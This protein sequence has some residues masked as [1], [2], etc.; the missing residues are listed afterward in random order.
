MKRYAWLWLS[1]VVAVLMLSGCARDAAP[2][3]APSPSPTD[4]SSAGTT[5]TP[6]VL[7]RTVA[8]DG[9][10]VS[11]YPALALGFGG[12]VSGEVLTITVKPGD[13][14]QTGDLIAQLD[15]T[16]LQRSVADAERT[17]ARAR[18]DRALAQT[19]WER[20]IADADQALADA[21]RALTSA[22]LQYSNTSVEEAL[23][24]LNR[25]KD[26]EAQA[27]DNY[28]RAL[29][30]PWEPQDI[31][32][33]YYNG[34]QQA[35]RDRELAEMRYNDSRGANSANYLQLDAR[36]ADVDKAARARAALDAGLALTYD[37]AIED[38]EEQLAQ[39][40]EALA[41]AQ[42]VAPWKAV[43]L[44][45]DI[46]PRASV[47][48]GTPVVTLLSLE[49][50]LRFVS[51][52][53]SEQHIADIR[54]GQRTVVTLR[55]FPDTPLEGAVESVVPQERATTDGTARFTVRVRLGATEL[56]LLPGLTGRAEIFTEASADNP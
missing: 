36:Q 6:V 9:E 25:A 43:V 8:A 11:P 22:R 14:L 37:R 54:P 51:E 47:G 40:T 1:L 20:D 39:A 23:T 56:A 55:T 46:A 7:G 31:R 49:D 12:G 48:A 13:I 16:A 2:E 42:L 24:S 44:S 35:I 4:A 50:G 38:A 18:A 32:D 41:H 30:R 21:Q 29:D 17:L 3:V 10:L 53:L 34:W 26:A 27:E 15:E 52:N 45:V 19:Q 33:S 5:L 28:R